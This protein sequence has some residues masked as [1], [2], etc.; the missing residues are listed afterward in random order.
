MSDPAPQTLVPSRR[1]FLVVVDQTPECKVALRF[2]ARRAQHTG[3]IVTLLYV[4]PPAD[5]QQ[6]AGV[7]RMMREE[8]HQEAERA[9]HDAAKTVNDIVGATPELVI[10]E[11]RPADEICALLKE[12]RALCILVLATSPSK[13][14]PG[15]LVSLISAPG[16]NSYPIPVTVVPGTLTDEQVDA[17][18]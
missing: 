7:E 18:A 8:A 12:D 17:L 13:E 11:G 6:W 15:P 10:R 1:K 9:L 2:A 14:G 3:G 16:A 4:V 5:F